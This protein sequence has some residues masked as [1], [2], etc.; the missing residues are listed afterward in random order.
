MTILI[1]G[2]TG[3]IGSH[4]VLQLI[5]NKEEDLVILDNFSNSSAES[6]RRVEKL[7]DNKITIIEGDI[8]DAKAVD[9]VM[10]RNITSVIHF[11]GLKAVGE[12]TQMPI[13]YYDNN[14]NGT[15]VLLASM[16]KHGVK[17]IIFSSS[18][19]VYGDPESLPLTEESK[20]GGVT[21]P[22]G[23]SKLHIEEIL[24]DVCHSDPEFTAIAL[25]YFNPAGSDESGLIGEDPNGTPNNLMPYVTQVAVGKLEKLTIFGGDYDTHDGTG[26]RDYIHVVDLADGHVA[27]VQKIDGFPS[28]FHAINLG[29]GIG[30]SVLDIQKAF[31]TSTGM[32][33]KYQ[34]GPR[35]PGDIAACYAEPEKA[36]QLLGWQAK[37]NLEQM[38]RDAW[39]WQ[40]KNPTG[41][42]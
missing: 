24:S 17:N 16:K 19:T 31:E 25:R 41:Y 35:R 26:V 10:S 7:V 20:T 32:E 2:G 30:Y 29:T 22:Y 15:L 1:T 5:R 42:K 40:Q 8:R 36:K 6:I 14:V 28:G 3:Y 33:V 38:C 9:E 13:E 34:I 12:S 4:T 21:N 18:A 27:A 37:Y 11:A 39:N 23:R